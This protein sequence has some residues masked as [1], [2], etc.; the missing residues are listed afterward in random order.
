[1]LLLSFVFVG[2]RTRA[3]A[4]MRGRVKPSCRANPERR[5]KSTLR[6]DFEQ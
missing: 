4:C 1:M 5:T 3:R 6:P 2:T